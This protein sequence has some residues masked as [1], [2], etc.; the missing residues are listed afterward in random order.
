MNGDDASVVDIMKAAYNTGIIP[1]VTFTIPDDN[2]ACQQ[3]YS[4]APQYNPSTDLQAYRTHWLNQMKDFVQSLPSGW[5]SHFPL[6]T[7]FEIGN[8]E[9]DQKD[10]AYY[11]GGKYY[12]ALFAAAAQGIFTALG[13]A[14]GESAGSNRSNYTILTGSV[15][16]PSV[17]G[18]IK[19]PSPFAN[20]SN[21]Y[22]VSTAALNAAEQANIQYFR[23][24]PIRKVSGHGAAYDR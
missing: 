21:N 2:P 1:I 6:H 9:N 23:L 8:E 20:G 3:R 15:T 12:P 10:T 17:D 7:Y 22:Q 13:G 14:G 19:D 5:Q 16:N 4:P 11:G 24:Q 18:S